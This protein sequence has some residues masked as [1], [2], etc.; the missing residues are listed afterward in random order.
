MIVSKQSATFDGYSAFS[1][2]A[3]HSDMTKFDSADYTGFKRLFGELKRWENEICK[4]NRENRD[5]EIYGN[6]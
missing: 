6:C 1:I 4:V 2:H 3:N 5:V